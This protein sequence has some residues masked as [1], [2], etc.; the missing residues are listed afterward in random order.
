MKVLLIGGTRF[1]GHH[2]TERLIKEGHEVTLLHRGRTPSAFAGSVREMPADRSDKAAWAALPAGESWDMAVDLC[3]YTAA[4]TALAVEALAGR[5]GRFIHI[6]TG[7]VYLVLDPVPNPAREADFAGKPMP[8]PPPGPDRKEWDYG[9]GKRACEQALSEAGEKGFP[10]TTL[11]LS[12]VQGPRDAKLRLLAYIRRILDGG[13]LLVL[14]EDRERPIRHLYVKDFAACVCALLAGGA[15]PGETYNLSMDDDAVTLPI[16]LSEL[17]RALGRRTELRPVPASKL[18]AAGLDPAQ[19]SPLSGSWTSFLD[20]SRAKR[21]LG[22]RP[23]P[24]KEWLAETVRWYMS[25]VKSD[26]PGYEL[27]AREL[28]L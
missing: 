4:D 8:E 26:P 28:D 27:R 2:T 15:G 25:E 24:W 13:P 11:R 22:F 9:M 18:R 21:E 3:A 10:V 16:F 5:M 17:G 1:I 14:D 6:S 19:V 7:Q 12:V 20:P 23:T